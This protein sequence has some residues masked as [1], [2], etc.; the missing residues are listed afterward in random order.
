MLEELKKR[1]MRPICF[2]LITDLSHLHGEMS[3]ELTGKKDFF[4]IKP[5]GVD[6]EKLT[7]EDMVVVDLNGN[8]IEEI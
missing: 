7:P 6:Y 4:V 8:K 5:S 3:A 2:F 1:S